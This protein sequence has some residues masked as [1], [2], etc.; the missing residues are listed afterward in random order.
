[1]TRDEFRKR[2]GQHLDERPRRAGP[3]GV[4][5]SAAPPLVRVITNLISTESSQDREPLRDDPA[6]SDRNKVIPNKLTI[7]TQ[8]GSAIK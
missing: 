4:V 7:C 6:I 5:V 8:T 1:V 2:Q 3:V